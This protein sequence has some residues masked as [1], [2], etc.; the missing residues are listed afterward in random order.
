M[1][2]LGPFIA[3]ARLIP[4]DEDPPRPQRPRRP[5]PVDYVPKAVTK[6]RTAPAPVGYEHPDYPWIPFKSAGP[7]LAGQ[8]RAW[9][10]Q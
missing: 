8:V 4:P 9:A 2:V 1:A 3:R 5:A 6:A 10:G 7:V